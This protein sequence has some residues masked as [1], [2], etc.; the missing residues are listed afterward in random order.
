M[1]NIIPI[2]PVPAPDEPRVVQMQCGAEGCGNRTFILRVDID[3]EGDEYYSAECAS[4]QS[5][6]LQV[7]SDNVEH[8]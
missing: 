6:A 3:D 4:C 2:R 5:V 7:M 1:S 8:S